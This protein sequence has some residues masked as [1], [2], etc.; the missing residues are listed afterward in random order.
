MSSYS[1]LGWAKN[2]MPILTTGGNEMMSEFWGHNMGFRSFTHFNPI[3]IKGVMDDVSQIDSI[4]EMCEL[5]LGDFK[6]VWNQFINKES[7]S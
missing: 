5:H 2:L 1:K 4:D 3:I 7:Q 6:M